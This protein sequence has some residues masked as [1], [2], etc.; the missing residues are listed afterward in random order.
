VNIFMTSAAGFLVFMAIG[1]LSANWL[2]LEG[3]I[4]YIFTFLVGALGMAA[5]AFVYSLMDKRRA[6]KEAQSSGA[7]PAASSPSSEGGDAA[8]WVREANTRL[9]QSKAGVG[10]E[11]LPMVFVIG[12]RGTAKTSTLLNSGLE[13]ELLTGQVYQDNAVTPTRGANIFYGRDSVFVEAGGSL[14]ANPAAWKLL[15]A[16]LRPGRLKS[17]V[18][19]SGQ[20]PRGVLLCFDLETFSRRGAADAIGSAARYLHDR[21]GD[22]SE[23]L[24]ISF[25][26]YV[27]FT[28]ADRIPFFAD[29]VRNLTNEEVGQVVGVTL[30]MRNEASGIYAEAETQRLTAGFNELFHSFCDQRLR[31]LPREADPQAVPAAYEFAREFRKLRAMLVQFLV[32][33]ARPSQLR[34]SPFL[35]GFYFSGVRPVQVQDVPAT[36]L[37]QPAAPAQAEVGGA[38]RM[39][40][41]GFQ[42]E[43]RAAQAQSPQAS[44]G[45]RVPQWLFLGHLFHDVILADGAA[46]AASGSSVK[47][48]MTK[49]IL[50]ATAAGLCLIYSGLLMMSF[51]GNRTLEQNALTAANAIGTAQ[52]AG[53]ALPT[54]DA[55]R[56]LETLR[57]SLQQITDYETKGKPLSLRWGLYKGSEMLPHL[58]A[59]YY[60]KFRQLLFGG[61]QDQ[62]VAYMKKTPATPGPGDDYGFGYD[63]VKAYLL[64][65][66]EWTRSSD[67]SLQTFLG[68]RLMDRWNAG[69]DADIGKERMDLAK[70]Q[71]DFY[72]RD[73]H[74]GNPYPEPGDAAAVEH[75]RIYLSKFS[76]IEWVYQ[77]LLAEAAK[78]NPATSFNRKFT[79]SAEAV[80][81]TVE[82]AWA[83]TREGW[84]FMQD[85]LKKKNFGGEPWVLGSYM[86]Q[87]VDKDALE[88]GIRDRYATDYVKQWRE[89]LRR[90]NVNGYASYPD[91]SRKLT[92]LTGPNA[93]LLALFWWTSY[94]TGIDL[95][96]VADKFRAVHKVVPPSTEPLYNAPPAQPY[97]NGLM[98]LQASVANVAS[99]G[100]DAAVKTSAD[101]ARLN[102]RQLAS[103]FPSDPEAHIEQ[104]T[105]DLL[106]QPIKNLEGIGIG[107][108]SAAGKNFCEAFGKLT[109]K[110]PFKVDAKTDVGLDELAGILQPGSGRLA[111]FYEG[112]LKEF[113]K[114]QN[115][116]CTATNPAITQAFL[117]FL[118]NMMQFSKALYAAPG[119]EMKYNYTLQ[120]VKSDQVDALIIGVNGAPSELK[121]GA[122][123]MLVWPGPGTPGFQLALR[124]QGSSTTLGPPPYDGVWGLFHFFA[125]AET[126]SAT[127]TGYTFGWT[128]RAGGLDS[129]PMQVE[130]KSVT[131]NIYVET[132]GAPAIFSQAFLSTLRCRGPFE[133]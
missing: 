104:R 77:F 25:P 48:S 96:G 20:A 125:N 12:D 63:T 72:G 74:N 32:D 66:S 30:P 71:F 114:C 31:L 132:N 76:G 58:R 70:L 111:M 9:A 23:V 119:A 67:Q 112:P 103:T 101:A 128:L 62:L 127:G 64:T 40:R 82:V 108:L 95:P 26:V 6:R 38:T 116:Q 110:F 36:P 100:G 28:R 94:N 5:S 17:L 10:I 61:T 97:T 13:P 91:A 78:K 124:L 8:R 16:K 107:G 4:Y 50:L 88:A 42:A 49:R 99:P 133:R 84:A 117:A 79:G 83:Y 59:L 35:R 122:S 105:A 73:L 121:I 51:F 106:E 14:M 75:G 1:A 80:T 41:A 7:A 120:P 53:T 89:V 93:P 60:A 34:A 69:R 115:G 130:G 47:T 37:A 86:P 85:Q 3:P 18:G 45:R 19:G 33:I 68:Q 39:F 46:R 55:L 54:E 102:Q 81:S 113:V 87:N 27:L 109:G 118:G 129:R 15:V 22:I 43:Q 2:H 131:Y 57:Q 21:L 11:N 29:F 90:S 44:A 65:T 98:G 52:V 56:R 24:G 92:L 126:R 123:K